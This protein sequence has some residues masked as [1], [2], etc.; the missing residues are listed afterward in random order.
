MP[1]TALAGGRPVT[2]NLLGVSLLKFRPDLERKYMLDA[3]EKGPGDDWPGEKSMA[4]AFAREFAA[5]QSAPF[6][7]LLT[8]GTHTLQVALETLDI[9]FGDEVIVP[10]LTWQA[11]ASAVCDVNA[12]PI[13][14]DVEP[15]TMCIDPVA[16]ERAITRRTRAVMP[17]HLYN[18]MADLDRIME[19]ARRHR[20]HVIEDCA[21]SHGSQWDG[22]GAGSRGD[23]G[24]FSFQSSKMMR[25]FEGGALLVSREDNYWKVVSQRSCGREYRPGVRVHSGN[26]RL[27]SLQAAILRGQLVAMKR[28][29]PLID[30]AGKAL[31]AAVAAAPGV[32]ALRRS[33]PITR[34]TGYCYGFLFDPAAWDGI[35]GET[36]RR[37]LSAELSWSFDTT[38]TPLS[39]S[40]LYYPHTKRRHALSR[41]YLR[42]ITPSRWDLP[43]ADALWKDGAVL[44][45][46][47]IFGLA[48]ARAPLLT[49]AVAKLFE[50]RD[51]LRVL[52]DSPTAGTRRA[53][54]R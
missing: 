15:D 52:Q 34:Q 53:L 5:F 29:A 21:H 16:V 32:R 11:T 6:C 28:N 17:V 4:E 23:F 37:A 38:Y 18:R 33:T 20:L 39:H 49:E 27:T 7:A 35:T 2:K 24:S 41:G 48:P 22:R 50:N 12:V 1:K 45:G 19:I 40:E 25:S 13:L 51:E 26:Y 9:G 42:A 46:W 30:R 47:P 10:G 36:F 8:N 43:V 3:F 14:V 44:T 31:D 54:W